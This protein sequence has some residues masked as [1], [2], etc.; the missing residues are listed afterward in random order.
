MNISPP[1][2]APTV[3]RMSSCE[4]AVAAQALRVGVD[5]QEVEALLGVGDPAAGQEQHPHVAAGDLAFEPF[6]CLEDVVGRLSRPP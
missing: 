4:I 3:L 6:Q 1:A 5:G 2:S